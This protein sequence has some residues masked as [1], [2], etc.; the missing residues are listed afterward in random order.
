M[1]KV[2]LK[3]FILGV[4]VATLGQLGLSQHQATTL[5]AAK[6]SMAKRLL[7]DL[8]TGWN[9]AVGLETYGTYVD[10]INIQPQ[11]G[12]FLMAHNHA[13]GGGIA[14]NENGEYEIFINP[15]VSAERMAHTLAHELQHIRDE[16]TADRILRQHPEIYQRIKETTQ[17]IKQGQSLRAITERKIETNYIM[18]ALF[19]TEYRAHTLNLVLQEEGLGDFF[20]KNKEQVL[21]HVEKG[22]IHRHGFRLS[23]AD[24]EHLT[25]ACAYQKA[26]QPVSP[27][28]S[29]LESNF[30]AVGLEKDPS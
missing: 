26:P 27:M 16:M 30:P 19:C 13:D 10:A 3:L 4:L 5:F 28:Q 23:A 9:F 7:A 2:Q 12:S 6:L 21:S 18:Q 1:G 29:L 22:Y 24:T 25:E 8:P 14:Q 20:L 15:E 17:W 11:S